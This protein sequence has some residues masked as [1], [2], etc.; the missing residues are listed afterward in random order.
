MNL[1]ID[2]SQIIGKGL[3]SKCFI[4]KGQQIGIIK[5][6]RTVVK[7]FVGPMIKKSL[8]WIGCGRYT[9]IVTDDSIFRFINHSCDP[10]AYIIGA[11]TV[12]AARDIPAGTEITMDYSLTE[13]DPDYLLPN[14]CTCKSH[15]CRKLIG[16]IFSLSQKQFKSKAVL[17]NRR[18]KKIYL[19][20]KRR[21]LD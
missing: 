12:R 9:W 16:S 18:F 8:D 5:G 19:S 13:A 11:R 1:Y 6:P 21:K 7:K 17:I 2:K 3:F 10:N 20:G 4:K 14:V 15:D